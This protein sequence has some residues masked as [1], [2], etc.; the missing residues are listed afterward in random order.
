MIQKLPY[1]T[2]LRYTKLPNFLT[3][4]YVSDFMED[5]VVVHNNVSTTHMIDPFCQ[6]L[7]VHLIISARKS[8]F[9]QEIKVATEKLRSRHL[10]FN[11][12]I[13]SFC[14]S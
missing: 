3:C 13:S 7:I 4:I 1:P 10:L 11:V 9:L 12:E 5:T 8:Y 6:K 14:K 2:L